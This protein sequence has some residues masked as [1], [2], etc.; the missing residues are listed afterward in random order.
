MRVLFSKT[1]RKQLRDWQ[2]SNTSVISKI[3][4][5]IDDIKENGFLY[6]KGKP[7]Q[8]KYYKNPPRFSRHI[9]KP[10]RLVYSPTDSGDLLILSCKGH[11]DD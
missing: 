2:T 4:E 8:L 7:E 6:G 9:T 10:D 5:L 11:Y 1:A 3:D